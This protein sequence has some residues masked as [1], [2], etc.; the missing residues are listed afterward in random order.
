MSEIKGAEVYVISTTL[1][2]T[3]IDSI[4]VENDA[5]TIIWKDERGDT[6]KVFEAMEKA[7]NYRRSK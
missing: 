7:Y 2:V 6:P 4:G 3:K 5:V 1:D